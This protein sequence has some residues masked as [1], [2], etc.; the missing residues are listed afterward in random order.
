MFVQNTEGYEEKQRRLADT[1]IKV[2]CQRIV[3]ILQPKFISNDE[4]W[5]HSQKK[6][7]A[8]QIKQ[9]KLIILRLRKDPSAIEKQTFLEPQRT[10]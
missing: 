2:P 8:V 9:R 10:T 5:R 6:P 7:V 3:K 1:D 4:M